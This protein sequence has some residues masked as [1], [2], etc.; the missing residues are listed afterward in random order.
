MVRR[1]M[2]RAPGPNDLWWKEHQLTC[3]GTFIKV[4]EPEAKNKGK[5]T[6]ENNPKVSN[7]PKTNG[8]L[9]PKNGPGNNFW[10]PKGATSGNKPPLPSVPKTNFGS[11]SSTVPKQQPIVSGEFKKI[12]TNTNNVHGWGIGGPGATNG[13]SN[14]NG[15]KVLP[16]GVNRGSTASTETAANGPKFVFSGA[17]GGLTTGRSRLLDAVPPTRQLD[18]KEEE[19]DCPV[20][21]KKVARSKFNE[22]L[23]KCVNFDSSMGNFFEDDFEAKG[24]EII[25]LEGGTKKRKI[26]NDDPVVAKQPKIDLTATDTEEQMGACPVCNKEMPISKVNNHLNDC[27][28]KDSE[29]CVLQ[30]TKSNCPIC[31]VELDVDKIFD[32]LDECQQINDAMQDM[33]IQGDKKPEV[34]TLETEVPTSKEPVACPVC[35]N[36]FPQDKMNAHLDICINNKPSTSRSSCTNGSFEDVRGKSLVVTISDNEDE[37]EVTAITSTPVK[38]SEK[39]LKCLVCGKILRPGVTL[40]LHL[41]ECVSSC[42]NDEPI[43]DLSSFEPSSL[44]EPSL[45]EAKETTPLPIKRESTKP[46]DEEKLP[47]YP[48]PVCMKLF[49]VDQM[50]AHLDTCLGA[51]FNEDY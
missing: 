31:K 34:V 24:V 44:S 21:D 48:C 40:N 16:P 23:D 49:A 33:V 38:N 41:E 2:N 26:T 50:N 37:A 19:Y 18:S 25:D 20:C 46:D 17:V 43:D 4:R 11:T 36:K 10:A 35:K 8:S 5:R 12:G 3:G 27:L 15:T 32:H 7:V 42:F 6:R 14:R 22:H 1:A 30:V 29:E 9:P 45:S 51:S 47:S 28:L 39:G 13:T